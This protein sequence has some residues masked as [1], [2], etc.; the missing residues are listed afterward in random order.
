MTMYDVRDRDFLGR[1][2]SATKYP[3]TPTYHFMDPKSGMLQEDQT[4]SFA[5]HQFVQV[6]EKIDGTNARVVVFPRRREFR[7]AW[8][9][10]SREDLLACDEDAMPNGSLGIVDALS[11]TA[12]RICMTSPA[13]DFDKVRVYYFEVYGGNVG[14]NARQYTGDKTR[15]G[16]RLFDIMEFTSDQFD[17]VMGMSREQISAWRDRGNQP[18]L[19]WDDFLAVVQDVNLIRVPV[20][21]ALF[22]ASLVPATFAGAQHLMGEWLGEDGGYTH[23]GLDSG[24]L[25]R[26]EGVVFKSHDRKVTAKLRF[27]DYIS[28]IRRME[29]NAKAEAKKRALDAVVE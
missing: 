2:N 22:D 27:A 8:V 4:V 26:S 10:G 23:A 29:N 24:A 18:F 21:D 1:L 19:G 6:T 12:N 9:I 5:G 25:G 28:T 16:F 17:E 14:K 3:E 20:L 11:A 15:F 7:Q 13:S